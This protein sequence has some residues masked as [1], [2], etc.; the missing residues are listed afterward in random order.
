MN[1]FL[2]TSHLYECAGGDCNNL[3]LRAPEALTGLL[4]LEG[5]IA[6]PPA[7]TMAA[8]LDAESAVYLAHVHDKGHFV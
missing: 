3:V 8:N 4:V 2:H 7:A 1:G 6:P 5:E